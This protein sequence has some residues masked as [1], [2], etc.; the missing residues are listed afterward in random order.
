M[1]N[2]VFAINDCYY[3]DSTTGGSE[4]VKGECF[5]VEK[6]KWFEDSC[7]DDN[8][9]IEYLCESGGCQKEEKICPSGY[10]CS[11]G[12]C[13]KI[14]SCSD[15]DLYKDIYQRGSCEEYSSS[16]TERFIDTCADNKTLIEYYCTPG[17]KKCQSFTFD[18]STIGGGTC[19]NGKCTK[20]P[21]YEGEQKCYDSDGGVKQNIAGWCRDVEGQTNMQDSC[22]NV[23]LK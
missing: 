23:V 18:C 4:Y 20:Y 11:D 14:E 8:T 9:V 3:E 1:G 7:K 17:A 10:S 2:K 6:G 13:R 5:D 15:S 22:N 19:N 16:G 12:A 21:S